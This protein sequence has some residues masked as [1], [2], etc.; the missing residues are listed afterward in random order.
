MSSSKGSFNRSGSKFRPGSGRHG[1]SKGFENFKP[2]EH[3]LETNIELPRDM[4][5]TSKKR[6]LSSKQASSGG[7]RSNVHF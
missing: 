2:T 7:K 1:N 3:Q 5:Q 4:V 6:P